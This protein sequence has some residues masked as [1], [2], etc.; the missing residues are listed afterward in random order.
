MRFTKYYDGNLD[1]EITKIE[2]EK[3]DDLL[4]GGDYVLGIVDGELKRLIVLEDNE[5]FELYIIDE[6]GQRFDLPFVYIIS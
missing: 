5:D 3:Y 1:I 4:N 2:R 6:K